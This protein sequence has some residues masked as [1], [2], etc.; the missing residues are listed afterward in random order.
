MKKLGEFLAISVSH[1][2]RAPLRSITGF[3]QNLTRR[4]WGKTLD[5]EGQT[6][7]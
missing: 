7:C 3:A 5:E 1:D 4:L 6:D 2:L